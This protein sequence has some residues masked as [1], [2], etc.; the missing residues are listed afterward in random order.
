M[1]VYLD[2]KLVSV[3]LNSWLTLRTDDAMNRIFSENSADY[4][5]SFFLSKLLFN[6]NNR[7]QFSF[8]H[9]L[10]HYLQQAACANATCRCRVKLKSSIWSSRK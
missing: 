8:R 9:L 6:K 1:K 4:E 2:S 10:T 3:I 5:I 7:N